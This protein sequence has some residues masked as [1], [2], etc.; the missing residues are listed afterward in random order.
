MPESS[1]AG[2]VRVPSDIRAGATSFR[3]RSD[4]ASGR[5]H[6]ET[7]PTVNYVAH[8]TIRIHIALCYGTLAHECLTVKKPVE[9]RR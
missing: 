8:Y 3:S 4:I 2:R 9:S 6:D 7:V 1:T 5:Q